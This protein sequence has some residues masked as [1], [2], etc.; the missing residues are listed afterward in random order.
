MRPVQRPASHPIDTGGPGRAAEGRRCRPGPGSVQ[1]GHPGRTPWGSCRGRGLH[2]RAGAR[3]G[4]R[5]APLTQGCRL[6]SRRLG[7]LTPWAALECGRQGLLPP[8]VS[9]LQQQPRQRKPAAA[10]GGEH[11]GRQEASGGS[12]GGRGGE[13]ARGGFG[14]REEHPS[15]PVLPR[16]HGAE[17]LPAL[18]GTFDLRQHRRRA[19]ECDGLQLRP[20]GDERPRVEPRPVPARAAEGRH[21]LTGSAGEAGRAGQGS[22]RG[23]AR[24]SHDL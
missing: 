6:G 20:A 11:G 10:L 3:F 2:G 9:R 14:R 21:E 22:P 1:R 13:S 17:D 4:E 8:R 23:E 18:G 24:P 12:R 7:R 15:R 5:G 19:R 16:L